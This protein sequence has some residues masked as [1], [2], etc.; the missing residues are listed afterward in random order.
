[1]A[2]YKYGTN[3]TSVKVNH[4]PGGYSSINLAWDD[5][6]ASIGNKFD[7][8]NSEKRRAV[9]DPF[10]SR[11]GQR[12]PQEPEEFK[13]DKQPRNPQ[14]N[15]IGYNNQRDYPSNSQFKQIIQPKPQDI[16]GAPINFNEN[17]FQSKEDPYTSNDH[18]L[19]QNYFRPPEVENNY[20][21]QEANPREINYGQ[22]ALGGREHFY[23]PQQ[24]NLPPRA[25]E[26][27]NNVY[28]PEQ[29]YH[30]SNNAK[31]QYYQQPQYALPP[32][33]NNPSQQKYYQPN[34]NY[35]PQGAYKSSPAEDR[36]NA[37]GYIKNSV[38]VSNPPGGQSTFTFG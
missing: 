30:P 16:F 22:P 15:P 3:F 34:E 1:M 37:P 28:R 18:Q 29:G 12:Y 10:K 4:A 6:P 11:D 26:M 31:E 35:A 32:K 5:P 24:F 21:K 13:Y 20:F 2:E 19:P 17:Y 9:Q 8:K 36:R 33:H 7:V 14:V 27:E 38:R 25:P 23:S